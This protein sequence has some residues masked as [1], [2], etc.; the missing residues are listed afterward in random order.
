MHPLS[1]VLNCPLYL[2]STINTLVTRPL[3]EID[4]PD[5]FVSFMIRHGVV[6]LT[7]IFLAGGAGDTTG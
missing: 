6:E 5:D 7:R 3:H 2:H 4:N 1:A